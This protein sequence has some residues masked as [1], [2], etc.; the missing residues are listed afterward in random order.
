MFA[1]FSGYTDMA[2]GSAQ[3]LGFRLMENFNNPFIATSVSKFWRRWHISLSSWVNEYIFNPIIINRRS[4]NKWAVV[5]AGFITFLILGFWHGA[6]W[7]YII[8][9]FLQG[10]IISAE[11]LTRKIR[12]GIR[13]HIPM[14]INNLVGMAFVF[15]YF[16]FS[17]IFFKSPTTINAFSILQKIISFNG[18]LFIDLNTM[19]YGIAGTIF[20]T[21]IGL[22]GYINDYGSL[23]F[24]NNHWLIEQLAY[25]SLIIL[26]LLTGVFDG[27]QFIYF[28][29]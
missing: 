8:F 11:F 24:K 29:F 14:W 22:I 6:S 23:P 7:N 2:I 25:T 4:W 27:S 21:I 10:F 5:Y 16:T 1:D 13:S 3:I 9:G 19:L 12:K 28:Q 20:L 17:L 18:S 26:I 15:G